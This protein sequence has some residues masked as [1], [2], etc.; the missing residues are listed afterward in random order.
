MLGDNQAALDL[1]TQNGACAVR[2]TTGCLANSYQENVAIQG[3]FLQ[4]LFNT[5]LAI[6]CLYGLEKNV[7]QYLLM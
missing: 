3:I 2:H 7:S 4:I 5:T 6:D 1:M